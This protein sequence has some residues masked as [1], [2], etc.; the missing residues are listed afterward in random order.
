M[1]YCQGTR[2]KLSGSAPVV[3]PLHAT[4]KNRPH[5]NDARIAMQLGRAY[6]AAKGFGAARTHYFKAADRGNAYAQ[7]NLGERPNDNHL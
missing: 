1:S 7:N 2:G 6:E 3:R 5:Q 4:R